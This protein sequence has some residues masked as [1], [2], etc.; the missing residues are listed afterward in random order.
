MPGEGADQGC[1]GARGRGIGG[2]VHAGKGRHRHVD[3]E[4]LPIDIHR[5]CVDR[6]NRRHLPPRHDGAPHASQGRVKAERIAT[7]RAGDTLNALFKASAA[8]VEG[9]GGGGNGSVG[10]G[11][12]ERN[13]TIGRTPAPPPPDGRRNEYGVDR[14]P[15]RA[16]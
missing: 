16:V 2:R 8:V 6:A 11:V 9:G 12:R 1:D 15:R 10:G 5:F 7:Q 4:A 13:T 3:G 14:S